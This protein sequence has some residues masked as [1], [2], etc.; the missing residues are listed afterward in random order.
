M[1]VGQ[2]R[3][4]RWLK[5]WG[6]SLLLVLGILGGAGGVLLTYPKGPLPSAYF[7]HLFMALAVASF[8]GL[9]IEL[10]LQR[11]LARN[12]FEAALG[13]LLPDRL[14]TELRW[15]YNQQIIATQ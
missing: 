1:S 7:E 8:I 4:D 2:D 3:I 5:R 9:F 12:V 14:K 10:T 6:V 13:Y 15:V 11:R